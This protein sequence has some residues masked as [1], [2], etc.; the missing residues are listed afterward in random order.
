LNLR[1][2]DQFTSFENMGAIFNRSSR[3]SLNFLLRV[4]LLLQ[5][6]TSFRINHSN[7]WNCFWELLQVEILFSNFSV[8][9]VKYI[10]GLLEVFEYWSVIIDLP[11]HEQ[12]RRVDEQHWVLLFF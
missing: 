1:V 5:W 11:T 10:K 7:E 3:S 9:T 4:F 8:V 6:F 2:E 12:F